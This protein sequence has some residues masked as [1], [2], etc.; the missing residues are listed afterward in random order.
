MRVKECHIKFLQY[1]DAIHSLVA[2]QDNFTHFKALVNIHRHVP[3]F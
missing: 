2:I 3:N 1:T